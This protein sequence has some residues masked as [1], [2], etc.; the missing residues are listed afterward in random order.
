MAG[1]LR[2]SD[3][4]KARVGRRTVAFDGRKVVME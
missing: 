2:K 4:A 3:G 1:L